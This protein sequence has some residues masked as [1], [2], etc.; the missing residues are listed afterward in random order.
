MSFEYN[1]HKSPEV[2]HYGCEAPRAYFVPY[3]SEASALTDNRAAS[4][5]FFSLCG[6]WDFKFYPVPS[7]IEDFT[8]EGFYRCG[9]DKMT[10]P[11]SWQTVLGKGYD[12][13]NYTNV[14]YPYP[15]DPPHVPDANPSALYVR[16]FELTENYLDGK[17][18]YINFEGVDSCFYLYINDKF[19][20]YSQVSHMTSEFK[21]TDKLV[22]GKNTIKVLVFKWCDGSYLEDQ[23]KFRYSGIFREVY[24]L[25]RDQAHIADLYCRQSINAKYTQAVLKVETELT[26]K[27]QIDYKLLDPKGH[28]ES[29]GS[30]TLDGSGAF[31]MLVSNPKLWS[32]ETPVLYTLV[33]KCGEEYIVQFVGFRTIEIKN[34]IVYINGQKV[35]VHGANRHDS[36]PILGSATPTDH[37]LEDLYI[38]KR[39]NFNMIRT[40]HYPNDPRFYT[41]CDKLGFFVCDETDYETHGMQRVGDWDYFSREEAWAE[42]LLDRA[43]RMFERDKN[44]P[45]IIMWSL[46]NESGLGENQE[47]MSNYIKSRLPGAIVHCEDVSRRLWKT[48]TRAKDIVDVGKYSE[49][50]EFDWYDVESRMYPSFDEMKK[51]LTD[52]KYTKPYFLCE[53][54]HAMGLG[55]GDLKQYWDLIYANDHFFGGCVWELIDH[56]VAT[57]DDIYRDP[58]YVYGG[59]FGDFPHDGN[60]CVDGLVYP[61]RRPHTGIKEHKAVLKPFVISEVTAEGSFRIKNRRYFTSLDDLSLYWSVECDGKIIRD[62]VINELKIAPQRSRKYQLDLEGLNICGI[63]TINFSVRQIKSTPWAP[64]GFEV[65]SHQ[66]KIAVAPRANIDTAVKNAPVKVCENDKAITVKVGETSYKI[67]KT[68]GLIASITDN[69]K[70]MITTPITPIVFRAPTDNDRRIKSEWYNNGFDR[71]DVKCYSVAIES[72]DAN[73]VTIKASL[74]LGAK[75]LA[76]CAKIEATYTIDASGEIKIE[77][78]VNVAKDLPTLPRFGVQFEMPEGNEKLEYF[79]MGPGESYIDLCNSNHLGCFKTTVNE[80]FEPYVRPQENMAHADTEWVAVTGETRHGL[81]CISDGKPI[82]FN[83]SHFTPHQLASTAHDYE[84]VPKKE[85]VI[86][87][88]YRHTGIGSNSCGPSLLPEFRFDEKEFTFKVRILPAIMGNVDPFAKLN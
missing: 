64:A 6:D 15:I 66:E 76:P 59:D 84:L 57:G 35:K 82:S 87:L 75:L 55:P 31:E 60:F 73:S 78:N 43:R 14:N 39:Y 58:H 23:D 19:V 81:L 13:P 88:D 70:E 44:H 37:M 85:T 21:I 27:A 2:L 68:C 16:D 5:R 28:E 49:F 41:L 79:G 67:C 20:G 80:N 40:S 38:L 26:G 25:A 52:K 4:S 33:I 47:K 69:G 29:G 63:C 18:I 10:V 1:F 77:M 17:D 22:A 48:A 42:S 74:S 51:Y 62:G 83:C 56:S 72:A 45:S 65:G 36:H 54:C 71:T 61:D 9:F 7:M 50:Y 53:Y 8:A 11:R 30:I 12:T 46:G 24:L 86:N 34:R 3:H 32:D